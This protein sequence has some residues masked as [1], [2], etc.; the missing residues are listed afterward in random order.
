MVSGAASI[1]IVRVAPGG[2]KGL[3][4]ASRVSSGS[5]RRPPREPLG[6][7][8]KI[9]CFD[10]HLEHLPGAPKAASQGPPARRNLLATSSG[11]YTEAT[12]SGKLSRCVLGLVD[13]WARTLPATAVEVESANSMGVAF[14]QPPRP[15]ES[16]KGARWP[17]AI[18]ASF[19]Q[20]TH[21]RCRVGHRAWPA[22]L[23]RGRE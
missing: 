9:S 10:I 18:A 21:R 7:V 16:A 15:R 22:D 8:F 20:D 4:G 13:T 17:A 5:S 11:S 14:G 19:G 12:G 23:Q 6:G 1:P 3:P 2:P